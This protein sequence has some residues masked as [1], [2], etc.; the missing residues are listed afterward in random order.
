MKLFLS[1]TGLLMFFTSFHKAVLKPV[2]YDPRYIEISS[3]KY[4][5]ETFH[6]IYLKRDSNRVRAKYFAAADYNGNKVYQRYR[7]WSSGKNVI[8]VSSGTYMDYDGIPV[9]LTVDNGVVVNKNLTKDFDAL[10]VINAAGN[11]TVSNLK[12]GDLKL[13]SGVADTAKKYD[14]RKSAWDLQA[15]LKWTAAQEATVFQSHLLVYNNKL[16]V[17]FMNSSAGIAPRRFLAMGKDENGRPVHAIIQSTAYATLYNGTKK[18]LDFLNGFKNMEV[19]SM[20]NLDTGD[21]DVFK[22]YEKDGSYNNSIKGSKELD[23]AV[24]LLAYYFQ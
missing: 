23:A 12:D 19:T 14:L 7:K 2:A 13:K 20:I 15:F 4:K 11:I 22:L 24:N 3:V 21:Q 5:D 6:V 1:L 17:S 10:V 9:G 18:A 16:M 8:L